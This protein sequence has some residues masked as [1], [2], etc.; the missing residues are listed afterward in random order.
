VDSVKTYKNRT[1]ITAAPTK[2]QQNRS[3]KTDA[4]TYHQELSNSN[5]ECQ[6][7]SQRDSIEKVWQ[8]WPKVPGEAQQ[9]VHWN[10]KASERIHRQN[11]AWKTV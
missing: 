1:A 8:Q 7:N 6:A 5:F 3:P 11:N 2:H 4:I 9:F 10:R